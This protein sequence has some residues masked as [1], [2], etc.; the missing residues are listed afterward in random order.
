MINAILQ[1]MR[2][3]TDAEVEIEVGM[4]TQTQNHLELLSISLI[5]MMEKSQLPMTGR[6][7]RNT[8]WNGL[9]GSKLSHTTSLSE[10][11]QGIQIMLQNQWSKPLQLDKLMQSRILENLFTPVFNGLNLEPSVTK[12]HSSHALDM[13]TFQM[14]Q[15]ICSEI[16]SNMIVLG[17]LDAEWA[18]NIMIMI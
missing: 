17:Q 16:S 7:L 2:L 6:L 14:I 12:K 4:M 9:D 1:I 5:L 10:K 3:E 18:I 8:Q 13:L 11:L 15:N